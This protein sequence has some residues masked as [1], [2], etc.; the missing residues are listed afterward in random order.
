[1]NNGSNVVIEKKTLEGSGFEKNIRITFKEIQVKT[2][3]ITISVFNG[4]LPNGIDAVLDRVK[5]VGYSMSLSGGQIISGKNISFSVPV[6]GN[7]QLDLF[8]VNGAKIGTIA[9]LSIPAGAHNVLWNGTTSHG[10]KVTT[11]VAILR[12]TCSSGSMS[13]MVYVK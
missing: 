2:P 4:P 5:Q 6:S 11:N 10:A 1:M 9:N 7:A 12:L 8:Q 13:K 3:G